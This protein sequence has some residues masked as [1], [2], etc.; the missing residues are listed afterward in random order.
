MGT[1]SA[2][3]LVE[4]LPKML[5]E[6]H[7]DQENRHT[8]TASSRGGEEAVREDELTPEV[9][10]MAPTK[11]FNAGNISCAIWEREI[12]VNGRTINVL[13]ATVKC[14]FKTDNGSWQ[15]CSSFRRNEIPLLIHCL[16]KAF[17]EM[18]GE[19]RDLADEKVRPDTCCAR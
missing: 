7:K 5:E 11:T 8:T 18:I 16:Q 2:E 10:N 12:S 15:S 14:R 13:K 4:G 9:R 1:D 17:E 19:R 3:F 6:I